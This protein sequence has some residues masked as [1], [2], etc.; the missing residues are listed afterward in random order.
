MKQ[1]YHAIHDKVC[2]KCQKEKPLDDFR[3]NR[4]SPD[5]HE[6]CCK[7]CKRENER[8]KYYYTEIKPYL[9]QPPLFKLFKV[10]ARCRQEKDI[11]RFYNNK[12][13]L[14]GHTTQCKNC[15]DDYGYAHA[16][17]NKARKK[18]RY[19][20]NR[21]ARITKQKE[22]DL[23]HREENLI[24]YRAY[25]P[26]YYEVNREKILA[27]SRADYVANPKKALERCMRYNARKKNAT[28]GKVDYNHILDRDGWWC[29][30]CETAIDPN[31]IKL[32]GLSFDHVIPLTPLKGSGRTPGSHCEENIKP[33]HLVCNIRK[34]NRLLEELSPY[35]RRG[36]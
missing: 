32:I 11:E 29:H 19:Q 14:D 33:A 21:E 9:M 13:S 7:K 2:S 1:V 27:R 10:C 6:A 30:I 20:A 23:L 31:A 36:L 12:N 22:Y 4:A 18:V 5:K 28:I 35:L 25:H 26:G 3:V 8:E 16:E 24:K 17:E 34:G 15:I